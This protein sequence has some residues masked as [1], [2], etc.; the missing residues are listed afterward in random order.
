MKLYGTSLSPYT[1]RVILV[2]RAKG[3]G[4]P[5]L[6]WPLQ[7]PDREAFLAINPQGKIP[8]LDDDGLHLP[9]SAVIADYL[10]TVLPGP[11]LWPAEPRAR[12]R[13]ALLARFIDVSIAPGVTNYTRALL[14]GAPNAD[15]VDETW[16][17]FAAG[18]EALEYYR[19]RSG[20]WLNGVSFGHSD[21]ALLPF[22]YGISRFADLT[23]IGAALASLTD[24]Q[25]YWDRATR[26][27]F[28]AE[29]LAEAQVRAD[30]VYGEG[31]PLHEGLNRLKT[32]VVEGRADPSV[33]IAGRFPWF[34]SWRR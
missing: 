11:S 30:L 4:L 23:A 16:A 31:G 25:A 17:Q 24:F 3:S 10:D 9:E 32:A 29:L 21:A 1:G 8:F 28:V 22:L 33:A 34:R 6:P 15:V 20:P 19:D 27:P 13:E 2:L 5:V 14:A 26:V 12:A 7:G 18:L